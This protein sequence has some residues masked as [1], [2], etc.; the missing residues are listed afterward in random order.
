ML[1]ISRYSYTRQL[2]MNHMQFWPNDL[3]F[4]S[5]EAIW[6]QIHFYLN[7]SWNRGRTLVMGPMCFP[8]TNALTNMQD[9]YLAHHVTLTRSQVLIFMFY[10]YYWQGRSIR[11]PLPPSGFHVS[12]PNDWR[13]HAET[14]TFKGHSLLTFCELFFG[15]RSGQTR[16]PDQVKWP[17]LQKY[18]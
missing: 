18:L 17:N 6:G 4:R 12:L 9:A 5:L 3:S 8:H 2:L 13:W 11:S 14:L 16:S 15:T 1:F 7:F 10:L